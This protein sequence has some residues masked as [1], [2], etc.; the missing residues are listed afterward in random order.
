[1]NI[2]HFRE[3]ISTTPG[4][5]SFLVFLPTRTN[6]QQVQTD[7]QA[8]Y[9]NSGRN[10]MKKIFAAI[11]LGLFSVAAFADPCMDANVSPLGYSLDKSADEIHLEEQGC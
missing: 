11:A 9:L 1:M 4:F 10:E 7:V 2:S 3:A 5:Q 6:T 8:I